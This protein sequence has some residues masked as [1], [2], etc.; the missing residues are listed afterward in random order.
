MCLQRGHLRNNPHFVV[1]IFLTYKSAFPILPTTKSKFLLYY[2]IIPPSGHRPAEGVPPRRSL[3][4][5]PRPGPCPDKWNRSPDLALRGGGSLDRERQ[6][7]IQRN[8]A[9]KPR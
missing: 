7:V 9:L 8:L 3:P 1:K 5:P 4:L 6:G 2:N